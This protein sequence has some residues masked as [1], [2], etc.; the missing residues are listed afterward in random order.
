MKQF[1]RKA[2]NKTKLSNPDWNFCAF[3]NS[4][5]MF[6]LSLFTFYTHRD[7]NNEYFN[8]QIVYRAID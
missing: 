1:D 5:G 7:F 2:K 6:M 4:L 3:L 8:R